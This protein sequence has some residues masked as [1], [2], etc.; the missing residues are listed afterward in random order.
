MPAN[1]KRI[2]V[3]PKIMAGKPVIKGT[4]VPVYVVLGSLAAGMDYKEVMREYGIQ[5]QDIL[6]C[7]NYA[8]EVVT[9]EETYPLVARAK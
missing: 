7:L 5:F 4:R 8:T 2:V 9:S 1:A 3:D 6:A